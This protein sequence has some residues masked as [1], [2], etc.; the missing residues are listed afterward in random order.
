MDSKMR[1]LWLLFENADPLGKNMYVIF[2]AGDD[3]RQDM[4]TLQM[5][6]IMDKL[7]KKNN[8]DLMLNPY[9]VISTGG[10]IGMI[11]VVTRSNTISKIQ[12]QMSG[13][14][15]AFKDE[16]LF[17]WLQEKNPEEAE[18]K[19]AIEN[20]TSSCAGYCVATYVLGIGDRHNDNIMVQEDGH[21]F[22]IDFGHILGNFKKKFGFKRE[23][24]PFV[25]T[26]DWAFVMGGKGSVYYT[27]F[28]SQC[29]ASHQILR[30]NFRLFINLLS[31][32][33][34]SGMPELSTHED[35]MYVVETLSMDKDNADVM[36]FH[37]LIE[38]TGGQMSTRVNFFI[39]NLV[40]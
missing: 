7:W 13:A 35:I 32:M 37:E 30:K 4:L 15:G 34:I 17:K 10:Q 18:I 8:L 19:T 24:V 28:L 21:L 5:F 38:A 39:H 3:L 6:R 2:K 16:V 33:L 31:M 11:E 20:F 12:K 1:P 23:R 22:H 40:H 29:V 25:F 26:P 9:G 36:D 27:K 14:M